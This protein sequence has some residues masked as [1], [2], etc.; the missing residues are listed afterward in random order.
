MFDTIYAQVAAAIGAIVV[1]FAFLKGDEPERVGGGIYAIS[2]L[3]SLLVQE[4][5][6]LHGPQ[7]GLMMVDAVTLA[8]YA[9]VAWKSRRSWPVWASALQSL[10]VMTHV[11]TLV[12]VRPPMVAFYAVINGASYGVLLALAIGVFQAWRDRR[13]LGLE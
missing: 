2:A 5:T 6:R 12:D 8:A 10:I 7:W 3:A 11:L 13:V 1:A 4:E 9:A